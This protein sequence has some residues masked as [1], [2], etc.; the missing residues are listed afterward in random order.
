MKNYNIQNQ[1]ELLERSL[2]T[3][4]LAGEIILE[5]NKTKKL[6]L[7]HILP[8]KNQSKSG[9]NIS[10]WI[11]GNNNFNPFKISETARI[12]N[13]SPEKALKQIYIS[14]AFTCHQIKSLILNKL[15]NAIEK[16]DPSQII[17]TGL[18]KLFSQSDLRNSEIKKITNMLLNELKS[19]QNRKETLFFSTYQNKE[20]RI[21]SKLEK[22]SKILISVSE[23]N[24]RPKIEI[25][26]TNTE[27][28]RKNSINMNSV[29]N[30][31]LE[32]YVGGE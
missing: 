6:D 1:I 22:I 3:H 7:P 13:I 24:E 31:T 17:I 8:V 29:D 4:N 18:P 11:D 12:L 14:R 23:R 16:F 28:D 10:I 27:I 15:W 32:Q 5:K 2:E 9:E 25:E 20:N 19:F 21:L 26:Y 30:P